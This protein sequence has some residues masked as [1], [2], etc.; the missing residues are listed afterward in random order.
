MGGLR[1]SLWQKLSSSQGA[2]A[3]MWRETG[4][5]LL[6]VGDYVSLQRHISQSSWMT[7]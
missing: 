4:E 6:A 2:R 5:A 7:W 1:P 3:A